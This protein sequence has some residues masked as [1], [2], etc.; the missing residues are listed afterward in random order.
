MS[1]RL[2]TVIAGLLLLI[3]FAPL[4]CG[5]DRNEPIEQSEILQTKMNKNNQIDRTLMQEEKHI[6]RDENWITNRCW[7]NPSI[8]YCRESIQAWISKFSVLNKI[9]ELFGYETNCF[10]GFN[11]SIE[12]NFDLLYTVFI[13]ID[14]MVVLLNIWIWRDVLNG[15]LA[16]IA[17]RIW[18]N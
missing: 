7:D 4:L 13:I 8:F 2:R 9:N 6:Q 14:V 16:L 17:R 10:F 5:V 18:Y 12:N 1:S 11:V 15:K 3:I